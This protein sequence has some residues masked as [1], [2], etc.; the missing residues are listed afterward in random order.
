MHTHT[1]TV[2]CVFRRMLTSGQKC[3]LTFLQILFCFILLCS[4]IFHAHRWLQEPAHSI[5]SWSPHTTLFFKCNCV[6]PRNGV[7]LRIQTL[8][9]FCLDE[10]STFLDYAS[11]MSRMVV[12]IFLLRKTFTLPVPAWVL[13]GFSNFL[14]KNYMWGYLETLNYPWV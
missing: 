9:Q 14:Q 1:H 5:W 10:K 8:V 6:F 4:P 2:T 12:R 3:S 7:K 11:L 13:Y